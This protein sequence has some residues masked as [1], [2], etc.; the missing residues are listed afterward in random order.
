MGREKERLHEQYMPE[1]CNSKYQVLQYLMPASLFTQNFL[2]S[3]QPQMEKCLIHH[4][5]ANLDCWRLSALFKTRE[6]QIQAFTLKK[7]ELIFFL[8]KPISI[9]L[10]YEGSWPS[11]G[12]HGVIFV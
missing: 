4:Q 9:R 12:Y 6:Y 1:K 8:R 10:K 2:I 3:V 11:L 7:A 5:E